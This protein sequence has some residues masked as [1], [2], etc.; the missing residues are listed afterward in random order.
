MMVRVVSRLVSLTKSTIVI[1]S[2]MRWSRSAE[3]RKPS[4]HSKRGSHERPRVKMLEI[5]RLM[6]I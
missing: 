6:M 5:I 2:W 1:F 3:T 4:R